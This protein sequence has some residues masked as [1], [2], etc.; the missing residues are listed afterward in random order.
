MKYFT[1]MISIVCLVAV[2]LLVQIVHRFAGMFDELGTEIPKISQWILQSHGAFPMALVVVF[3][4]A[5]MIA[6]FLKDS[7]KAAWLTIATVFTMLL[8]AGLVIMMLYI[9]LTDAISQMQ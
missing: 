7:Q 6:A 2:A 4:I 8:C 1:C 9:P 5:A 3:A